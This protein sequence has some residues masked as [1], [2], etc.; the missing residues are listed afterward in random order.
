MRK[1]AMT[2]YDLMFIEDLTEELSSLYINEEYQ[3]MLPI[4]NDLITQLNQLKGDLMKGK[5][6]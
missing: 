6:V 4:V 2:K 5:Y 3:E 1:N